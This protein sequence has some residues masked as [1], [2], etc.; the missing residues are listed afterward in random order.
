MR[1]AAIAVGV[2]TL[3]LAP[4]ALGQDCIA[5]VWEEDFEQYTAGMELIPQQPCFPICPPGFSWQAWH[6]DP[7][8]GLSEVSDV[9][10]F[11]G[12]N[13]VAVV[14][15]TGSGGVVTVTGLPA[16]AAIPLAMLGT[17][18]IAIGID[19]FAYKPFRSSATI[20]VGS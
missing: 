4:A 14:G 12:L 7:N 18:A 17:A 11:E 2:A 9:Q 1:S 16:L 5:T 20:I 3:A 10:A 19:R 8:A 6:G 13:S 15:G